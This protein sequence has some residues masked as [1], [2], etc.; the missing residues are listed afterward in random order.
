MCADSDFVR[1]RPDIAPCEQCGS[2]V[3]FGRGFCLNCVLQEGLESDIA[4]A[5]KWEDVLEQ[6]DVDGAEWRVGNYQIL[7]KIGRGGMGIIYRARQINSQRIVALKR[8]LSFHVDSREALV[9]FQREI[10][11]AARQGEAHKRVQ[12]NEGSSI[13]TFCRSTKSAK[14]K[15]DGR[16]SP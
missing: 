8:I 13:Q 3:R 5:E 11:A 12:S 7:Q 16:S 10:G 6:V 4:N 2:P 9:R 1:T 14:P 15:T